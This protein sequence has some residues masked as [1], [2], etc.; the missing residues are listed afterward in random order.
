MMPAM[1]QSVPMTPRAMRPWR[2]MLG[3]KKPLT[4]KIYH[5]HFAWQAAAECGRVAHGQKPFAEQQ[6]SL[7]LDAVGC[8]GQRLFYLRLETESQ[9]ST[10]SRRGDD[11]H[12]FR[13]A[14]RV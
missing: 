13:R 7:G 12:V 5:S 8:G 11:V 10:R 9:H 3:R 6:F 1:R 4:C 14:E 2:L